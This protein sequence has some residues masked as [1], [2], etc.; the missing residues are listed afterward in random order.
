MKRILSCLFIAFVSLQTIQAQTHPPVQTIDT[1]TPFKIGTVGGSLPAGVVVHRFGSIPTNRTTANGSADLPKSGS[2]NAGG[3]S[4]SAAGI[5]LLGST[6][7][8]SGGAGAVVVAVNTKGKKNIQVKWTC[9]TVL[10]QTSRDNSIALQY[11]IGQSGA[12]KDVGDNGDVYTSNGKTVNHSQNFSL[13]LPAECDDKEEVQIRWVYW[14]SNSSSGS[15]DRIAV[16]KVEIENLGTLPVSVTNFTAKSIDQSVVLNWATASEQNNKY[17]E[18]ERS[19]DGEN[20]N[21][22]AVIAGAGT[23]TAVNNYAYTDYSAFAGTNYYRLS[24]QD[25]DG[26]TRVIET[27][28]VNSLSANKALTVYATASAV[29]VKLEAEKA[30]QAVVAIYDFNGRKLAEESAYVNAG[31]NNIAVNVDLLSGLYIV[32]AVANG[33]TSVVK[34]VK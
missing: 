3:W 12:F 26:T 27:I 10:Q 8:T 21:S 11:R 13:I 2:N 33:E 9:T 31:T 6:N 7:A 1:G 18:I 4:G 25:F 22:I 34:F 19:A 30:G 28:V 15:R 29:N 5:G 20:F 16:G 14:E 17:F 32:K 23:S 24:Q